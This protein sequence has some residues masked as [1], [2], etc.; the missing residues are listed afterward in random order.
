MCPSILL[1]YTPI[2]YSSTSTFAGTNRY[3]FEIA[4]ISVLTCSCDYRSIWIRIDLSIVWSCSSVYLRSTKSDVIIVHFVEIFAFKTHTISAGEPDFYCLSTNDRLTGNN[5]SPTGHG[6]RWLWITI[7]RN[8][9]LSDFGELLSTV[10]MTEQ[11]FCI[12]ILNLF[13][14]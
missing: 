7:P 8:Q 9:E 12:L 10:K 6:Y 5:I 1:A 11:V 13:E 2:W 4:S 14:K 3:H